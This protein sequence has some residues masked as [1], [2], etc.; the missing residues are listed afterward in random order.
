MKNAIEVLA[1]SLDESCQRFVK[2]SSRLRG[3]PNRLQL[4][5]LSKSNSSLIVVA[6][7]SPKGIDGVTR[8]VAKGKRRERE[9]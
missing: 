8:G 6:I 4:D 2:L 7:M 9:G 1:E 5:Y 3:L